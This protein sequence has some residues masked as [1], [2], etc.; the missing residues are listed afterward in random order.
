MGRKKA[1][2]CND[3]TC[4]R[5]VRLMALAG[6]L[7]FVMEPP[8]PPNAPPLFHGPN[9]PSDCFA[10]LKGGARVEDRREDLAELGRFGSLDAAVPGLALTAP[11]DT[12]SSPSSDAM[13]V[14]RED[15]TLGALVLPLESSG[16]GKE[17]WKDGE[18]GDAGEG[19]GAA[20]AIAHGLER[21]PRIC[22][23][24]PTLIGDQIIE[25]GRAN[26]VAGECW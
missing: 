25:A 12:N 10:L 7:E 24:K 4:D 18:R 14:M 1:C 17:F 21:C 9:V 26:D 8:G 6:L 5:E 13:S 22:M 20:G 2:D 16:L 15:V 19:N 23:L 3:G 11:S